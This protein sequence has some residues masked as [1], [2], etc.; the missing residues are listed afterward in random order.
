MEEFLGQ[1]VLLVL[2]GVLAPLLEPVGKSIKRALSV[3]RKIKKPATTKSQKNKGK[4]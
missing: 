2:A 4:R 3:R 1:V